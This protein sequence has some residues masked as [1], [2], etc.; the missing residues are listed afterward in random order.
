[1]RMRTR[2]LNVHPAALIQ[3]AVALI[4]GGNLTNQVVVFEEGR[5]IAW[6]NF[7]RHVWCWEL[8]PQGP[9]S[10]LVTETFDYSTNLVPWLLEAA[11]FPRRNATAMNASLRKLAELVEL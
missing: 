7:G 11:G 6:R 8:E 4:N 3:V 5:R 1:M 9:R 10:T 2:P